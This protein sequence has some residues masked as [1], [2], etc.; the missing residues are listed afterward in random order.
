MW[1]KRC[2]S[3]ALQKSLVYLVRWTMSSTGTC[4][5]VW[6]NYI[7]IRHPGLTLRSD[8]PFLNPHITLYYLLSY[9]RD[10][11]KIFW[12]VGLIV[13][14]ANA[15]KKSLEYLI[16]GLKARKENIYD[17]DQNY[18]HRESNSTSPLNYKKKSAKHAPLWSATEYPHGPG[19]H[20]WEYMQ[21]QKV[22]LL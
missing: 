12:H 4:A 19:H 2:V 14:R 21:K 10:W 20:L 1:S 9:S 22:L 16:T 11:C 3:F 15:P 5:G 8:S 17:A 13:F 7:R 6:G 18:H